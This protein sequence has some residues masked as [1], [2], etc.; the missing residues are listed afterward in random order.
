MPEK[1][2]KHKRSGVDTAFRI[3][4]HATSRIWLIFCLLLLAMGVY[5]LKD[6]VY[7][8]DHAADK[9]LLLYKPDETTHET[10]ATSDL[11]GYTGWLTLDGTTID[12]PVMQGMD[13][14]EY[15]NKDPY[16][17]FALSGSIFLDSRNNSSYT[18]EFNIIYGH[19]ME[20][21]VIRQNAMFGALDDY[22]DKEFF[23]KHR[24]GTLTVGKDVYN[25]K[26]FAIAEADE[27]SFL[28]S[29]DTPAK[30]VIDWLRENSVF[31][32]EP[33]GNTVL[34]LSTCKSYA[35][36]S[37][38]IVY[39]TYNV[40]RPGE[41]PKPEDKTADD[42]VVHE[43]K[44]RHNVQTYVSGITKWAVAASAAG[45]VIVLAAKA[46]KK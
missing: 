43:I 30:D 7:V 22:Y 32:S 35:D 29:T 1:T 19:H 40:N 20:H 14:A 44:E 37:R 17:K 34:A 46:R 38:T 25:L 39:C 36:G 8:Y 9:S 6:I 12:Y 2:N 33:S 4:D 31:F 13:N 28:F 27:S 45:I 11:K 3:L 15:L 42:K 5:S 26:V 41:E 16:G 21:S 10:R 24:E 23:K 18:D